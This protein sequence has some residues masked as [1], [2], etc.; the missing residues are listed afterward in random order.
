MIQCHVPDAHMS[1]GFISLA[2]A[3]AINVAPNLRPVN[4]YRCEEPI[5]LSAV[6]LKPQC[7]KCIPGHDSPYSKQGT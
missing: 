6:R 5:G 2:F 7:F 1:P 3:Y 4:D